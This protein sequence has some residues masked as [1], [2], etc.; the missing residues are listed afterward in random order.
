MTTKNKSDHETHYSCDARLKEKGGQATCCACD[1]H[2]GCEIGNIKLNIIGDTLKKQEEK[3][4]V[5]FL[6]QFLNE[7]PDWKGKM[8]T[9]ED[10]LRFI[11]IAIPKVATSEK[12]CGCEENKGGS[13]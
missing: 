4:K 8:W 2:D 7:S 10:I 12:E 5:G 1:F 3:P 9:D 6:R 13:V 11:D